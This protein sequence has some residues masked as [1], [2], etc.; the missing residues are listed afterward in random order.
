MFAKSSQHLL[1]SLQSFVTSEGL[2]LIKM[3]DPY[4]LHE[5]YSRTLVTIGA[6]FIAFHAP[7]WIRGWY[8]SRFEHNIPFVKVEAPAVSTTPLMTS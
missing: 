6:L 4:T 5:D 8:R 3:F 1:A 2:R 7:S